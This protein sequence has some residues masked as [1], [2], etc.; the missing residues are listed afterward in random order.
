MVRLFSRTF[1]VSE[2]IANSSFLDVGM[3]ILPSYLLEVQ[4]PTVLLFADSNH[5]FFQA[6]MTKIS[7]G[8]G[9]SALVIPSLSPE[10]V[11]ALLQKRT[12]SAATKSAS[13]PRR[14]IY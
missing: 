6:L 7:A 2:P 13:E 14:P 8:L 12:K 5:F 4:D 11:L 10:N 1:R 9:I 3:V